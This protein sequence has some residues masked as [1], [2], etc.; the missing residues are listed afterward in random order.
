MVLWGWPSHD[1]RGQHFVQGHTTEA[2]KSQ[3]WA[4]AAPSKAPWWEVRAPQTLSKLSLLEMARPG[5]M[6]EEALR[7]KP[8]L[9]IS[10]SFPST[11]EGKRNGWGQTSFPRAGTSRIL[12]GPTL[13]QG[14]TL[15]S[16]S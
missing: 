14:P 15:V 2:V 8:E 12:E 4:Q 9:G 6:R 11:L 7:N 3:S 1:Q 13:G 10:F 16:L 5:E